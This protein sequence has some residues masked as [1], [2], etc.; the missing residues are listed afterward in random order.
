[1]S[2]DDGAPG[3][4]E[5]QLGDR[6]HPLGLGQT[7]VHV[8]LDV[9][10]LNAFQRLDDFGVAQDLLLEA[11]A[12]SAPGGGPEVNDDGL[13]GGASGTESLFRQ[14][15]GVHKPP[16]LLPFVGSTQT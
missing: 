15:Q 2:L 7:Q 10:D 9:D 4:D 5:E 16:I 14:K 12:G 1:V 3:I 11:T 6:F 13:A 8:D